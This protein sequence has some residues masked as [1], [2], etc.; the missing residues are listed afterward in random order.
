MITCRE[1]V[2]LLI[3]LVTGELSPEYRAHCEKHLNC[4]PPCVTYLE[5]YKITIRL[6]RQLPN[7]PPPPE[8]MKRLWKLLEE[9]ERDV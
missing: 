3:D 9:S 8:L 2:E 4:C 7:E 6:T 5:T 1:C